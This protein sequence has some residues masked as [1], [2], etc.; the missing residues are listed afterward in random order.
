MC[1]NATFVIYNYDSNIL[2]YFDYYTI[3]IEL[4]GIVAF[5]SFI[6][7]Q[8]LC[9]GKKKKQFC[10]ENLRRFFLNKGFGSELN[11]K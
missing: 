11:G 2:D 5:F 4:S 1:V 10:F 3:N 7:H 6:V 8:K 9:R